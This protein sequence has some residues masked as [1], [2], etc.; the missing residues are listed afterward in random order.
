MN[1][2][3]GTENWSCATA[4]CH[5]EC[6]Q[7]D[8]LQSWSLSVECVTDQWRTSENVSFSWHSAW[9]SCENQEASWPLSCSSRLETARW[10]ATHLGWLGR[11][12]VCYLT[13]V[14]SIG[15]VNIQRLFILYLLLH[16]NMYVFWWTNTNMVFTYT[17]QPACQ[18]FGRLQVRP[19]E[20]CGYD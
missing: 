2:F 16:L 13:A 20:V 6:D 1:L 8:R 18:P 4:P 10:H 11:G 19:L 17:R 15:R 14:N 12:I 5:T 9:S 7:R 3:I